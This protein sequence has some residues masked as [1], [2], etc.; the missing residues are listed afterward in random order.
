MYNIP[1]EESVF[2]NEDNV[3]DLFSGMSA[4]AEVKTKL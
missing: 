4:R 3:I 1:Y 2:M